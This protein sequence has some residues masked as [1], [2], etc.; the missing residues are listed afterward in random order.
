MNNMSERWWSAV[1]IKW[2]G[3]FPISFRVVAP[4]K[5]AAYTVA[6]HKVREHLSAF[7]LLRVE[8]EVKDSERT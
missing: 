7:A 8:E 6:D 1:A 3:G 2:E 5:E 4:T